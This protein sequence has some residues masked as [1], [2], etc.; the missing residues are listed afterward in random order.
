MAGGPLFLLPSWAKMCIF[1]GYNNKRRHARF[2]QDDEAV[3]LPL[4][5]L[6]RRG[7]R[8]EHPVDRVQHLLVRR[9]RPAAEHPVQG[10]RRPV[11]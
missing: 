3:R 11:R 7:G 10:G 4:Q 2:H 9:H 1:V 5:V 8:P 6:P